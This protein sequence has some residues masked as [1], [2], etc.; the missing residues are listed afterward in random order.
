MPTGKS[1][2]NAMNDK[3]I[4]AK[5]RELIEFYGERLDANAMFLHIYH[6]VTAFIGLL[7]DQIDRRDHAALTCHMLGIGSIVQNFKH[8]L[9]LSNNCGVNNSIGIIQKL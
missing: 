4:I 3:L 5:Q 7:T 9:V 1:K 6:I 8:A 2:V